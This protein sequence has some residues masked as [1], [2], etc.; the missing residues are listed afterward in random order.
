M[1]QTSGKTGPRVGEGGGRG[2]QRACG[3][4]GG[5]SSPVSGGGGPEPQGTQQNPHQSL[6]G[7]AGLPGAGSTK[8][9][10]EWGRGRVPA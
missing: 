3:E 10:D 6:S 5:V 2:L 8:Q 4:G 7:M 9:R 1:T